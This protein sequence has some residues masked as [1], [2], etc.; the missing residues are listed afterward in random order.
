MRLHVLCMFVLL[1]LIVLIT[2]QQIEGFSA[3]GV[4]Q[5]T[6]GM[7]S[8]TIYIIVGSIAGILLLSG[9]FK[10]LSRTSSSNNNNN[11]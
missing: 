6:S 10:L 7:N 9:L 1:F 3:G 2:F 11:S 4:H 5:A 8:T